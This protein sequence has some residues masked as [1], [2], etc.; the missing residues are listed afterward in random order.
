MILHAQ[1][2]AKLLHQLFMDE[3]FHLT[4][5]RDVKLYKG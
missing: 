2:S 5:N 3:L 1:T 4:E